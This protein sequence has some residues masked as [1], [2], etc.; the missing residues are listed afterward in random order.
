MRIAFVGKGG[1]GKTTLTSLFANYVAK[2]TQKNI[3]L[4]DADMNIH[5]GDLLGFENIVGYMVNIF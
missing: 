4:F 3:T 2:K 5:V 1:A